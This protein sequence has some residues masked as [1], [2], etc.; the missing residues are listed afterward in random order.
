VIATNAS[1][2]KQEAC[3]VARQTHIAY[4]RCISPVHTRFDGDVIFCLANG[5]VE[6]DPQIVGVLAIEA[7]ERAILEAVLRARAIPGLPSAA[8]LD[9]PPTGPIRKPGSGQY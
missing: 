4:A 1:L 6:A 3:F 8:D 2:G 5:R 7:M 9:G